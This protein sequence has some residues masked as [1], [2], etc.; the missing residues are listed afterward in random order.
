MSKKWTLNL[1]DWKKIGKNALM[2]SAPAL[3]IFF[4]QL[5]QG[6]EI[7]KA[8]WVAIFVIYGLLADLFKKFS[9]GR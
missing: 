4:Y 3:A 1:G 7:E 2:F 6:V 5:S 9:A 8:L